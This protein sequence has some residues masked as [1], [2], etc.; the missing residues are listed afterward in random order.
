VAE[1]EQILDAERFKGYISIR[2]AFCKRRIKT[3][4]AASVKK[5]V[6]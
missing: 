5:G 2:V 6:F 4:R 3:R 1:I